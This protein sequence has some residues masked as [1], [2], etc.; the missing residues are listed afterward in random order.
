MSINIALRYW[1]DQALNHGPLNSEDYKSAKKVL[2]E[3]TISEQPDDC[4]AAFDEKWP[5]AK[6]MDLT[7]PEDHAQLHLIWIGFEAAWKPMREYRSCTMASV[8]GKKMHC[9]I[10]QKTLNEALTKTTSTEGKS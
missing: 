2:I 3:A 4:R 10:K 6:S 5:A 7:T 8:Y 1:L 9:D